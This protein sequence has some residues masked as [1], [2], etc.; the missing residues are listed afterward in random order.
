MEHPFLENLHF[1]FQTEDKLYMVSDYITGGELFYYLQQDH[2]FEENTAR[3]YAAQIICVI[4][5]L[6][7]MGKVY[8]DLKPEVMILHSIT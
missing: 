3:L 6:H 2:R 8:E 1:C 5:Y 7:S 4:S